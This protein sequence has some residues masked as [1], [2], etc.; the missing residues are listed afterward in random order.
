MALEAAKAVRGKGIEGE[1]RPALA[2]RVRRVRGIARLDRKA[3]IG[4][5]PRKG[6]DEGLGYVRAHWCG[7]PAC[8]QAVKENFS[9]TSR[10]I[11]DD[12][13]KGGSACVVCGKPAEHLV[14]WAKA[15]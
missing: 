2:H 1:F 10:C 6:L 4:V 11:R 8:E 15:Y 9:A 14:Y 13:M 12:E 7:D 3:K 5:V